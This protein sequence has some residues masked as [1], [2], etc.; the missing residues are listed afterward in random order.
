[1]DEL[2]LVEA[3]A[4]FR[5]ASRDHGPLLGFGTAP[6][7]CWA[8]G[9]FRHGMLLAPATADAVAA[10]VAARLDGAPDPLET[11]PLVAPFSPLRFSS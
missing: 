8:T 11:D 2:E 4:G 9:H 7:V 6:G 10:A 5:P 1:M 3:W